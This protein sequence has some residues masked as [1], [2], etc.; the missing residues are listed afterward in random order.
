MEL[1]HSGGWNS[2]ETPSISSA[3]FLW[4]LGGLEDRA[5]TWKWIVQ[6]TLKLARDQSGGEVLEYSLICGLIVL[7]VI[8]VIGKVGGKVLNR[9]TSLNSS[10]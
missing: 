3:F 10:M 6:A 1:W 2:E 4:H 8:G 5:M 7:G 9:W